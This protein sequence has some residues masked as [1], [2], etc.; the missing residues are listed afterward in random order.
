MKNWTYPRNKLISVRVNETLYEKANYL[1]KT[2]GSYKENTV[3]DLVEQALR[4]YINKN[5]SDVKM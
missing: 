1:L 3:S 5:S 2:K 4:Q